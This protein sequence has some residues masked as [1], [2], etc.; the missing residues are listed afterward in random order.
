[1]LSAIISDFDLQNAEHLQTL[2]T[3]L[4]ELKASALEQDT[5]EFDPSGTG[6]H[7]TVTEDGTVIHTTSS[8]DDESRF[9]ESEIATLTTGLSELSWD[10]LPASIRSG[11]DT[12]EELGPKEKETLL[13]EMFPTVDAYTVKHTLDKTNGV[14]Y[15]AMDTLLNLSFLGGG[16]EGLGEGG[17]LVPKGIEGFAAYSG[18]ARGR[19]RKGKRK[20]YPNSST[21][22]SSATSSIE[23]GGA[24]HHNK[25]LLAGQD[26]DFIRTRTNL[27]Q[28]AIKSKYHALGASLPATIRAFA[29]AEASKL[30]SIAH[31][32]P[33]MQLHLS[34]L[35]QDFPNVAMS[36]L[37]GLL[38]MARDNTSAAHELAEAMFKVSHQENATGGIHII[39]RH[40]PIDL[41]SDVEDTPPH[42][43]S[44]WMK[45]DYSTTRD[46]ALANN[47]QGQAALTKASAAYRR[48][49]S[50]HLMGGA[51]AYY[52]EVAREHMENSKRF[53]A[54]AAHSF[55]VSQSTSNM[56]DLHGVTVAD[57]TGIARAKVAEWWE[58]LGDAK[59]ASGGGGPARAGYHVVVGLG[60]HSKD[61]SS[62]LG[63]AVTKMLVREGWRVEI[64]QGELIVTGKV[65]R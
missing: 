21:R 57:A 18:N 15:R 43:P 32:E 31:L 63:P 20:E 3:T 48:G 53:Q 6:G 26:V 30:S 2:R 44:T 34:A 23:E 64:G 65:R 11:E 19:K 62:R 16:E 14:L 9:R 17:S 5:A 13:M 61:G 8:G 1:M 27:P 59:H 24:V 60:R 54:A 10:D 42:S 51:A 4:D 47:L 38:I 45:P 22:S 41:R 40:A 49:K 25:W 56:L 39:T 29:L 37:G 55:V 7:H 36:E 46:L 28:E 58:T 35:K 50:D 33:P 12:H 52:S